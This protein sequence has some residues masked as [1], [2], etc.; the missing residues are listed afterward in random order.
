MDPGAFPKILTP[1]EQEVLSVLGSG[2]D[3]EGAAQRLRV[4]RFTVGCHRRNIMGKLGVHRTPDLI[5]YAV[6]KGFAKLSSFR[7]RSAGR[8]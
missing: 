3:D 8:S 2:L 4:S 6:N 5:R 1:R 7:E